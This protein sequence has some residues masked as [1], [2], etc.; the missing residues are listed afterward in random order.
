MTDKAIPRKRLPALVLAAVLPGAAPGLHAL[1]VLSAADLAGYCM[2]GTGQG[3][4]PGERCTTYVH[5]FVDGA[6]ATD[7]QVTL[8]VTREM[9]S[10]EEFTQRALLERIG[11]R[12][13]RFGSSVYAEFCVPQPAPLS[14]ITGYVVEELRAVENDEEP[15]REVVYRAL[16]AN[17]PC[18]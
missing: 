11:A 6:V 15:A 13:E 3:G 17:Y 1:D 12:I 18:A 9:D 8:N 4:A 14:E 10:V 7:P 5:G 2:A 16:R